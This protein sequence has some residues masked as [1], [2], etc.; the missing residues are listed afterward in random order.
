MSHHHHQPLKP[1]PP[2]SKNLP[3]NVYGVIVGKI[4]GPLSDADN[5][6]IFIPVRIATGG[7]AGRYQ[8]AFNTESNQ[9]PAVQYHIHDEPIAMADVPGEEFTTDASLSY[10]DLGLHQ[11]GFRT[12]SN[13]K[14]RTIVHNSAMNSDLVAA[15]GF[16]F[17]DGSGLHDIHFNNGEKAGSGHANQPNK[18]GALVFYYL[19][20]SGQTTR[21]WIFIKFQSQSLP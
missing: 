12:V 9:G 7:H 5:N 18:D 6:H 4:D 3:H 16:T 15:Y 13:G 20:R 8:L 1:T 11:A 10:H 19:N 14:L 21:R 2:A 17:S